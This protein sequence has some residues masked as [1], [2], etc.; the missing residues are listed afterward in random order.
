M[1]EAFMEFD[2]DALREALG[3]ATP[4][5]LPPPSRRLI[6]AERRR[7]AR[8]IL[9]RRFEGI[10]LYRPLAVAENFHRSTVEKRVATGSN[11]SGKTLS[12]AAEAVR[13]WTGMDPYNKYRPTDGNSI[14]VGLDLDHCAMFWRKCTAPGQFSIIPDQETGM[15]RSVRPDP[16]NPK[17]IDPYDLAN[18]KQWR[19]AP[20]LIPER[21]IASIAWEDRGKGIPR[22]VTFTTGW[23]CLFRSSDGKAAQGDAF[24]LAIFDEEQASLE[25]YY[26]IVRGLVGQH[27]EWTSKL[28]WSATSQVANVELANLR[29]RAAAG[30]PGVAQFDMLLR[31]NPYFTEEAKREFEA[32]L[33]EDERLT[34]IEGIPALTVR[35]IYPTYAPQIDV[36]DGGHGCEPFEVDPAKFCRYVVIDP[37]IKHCTV[38]C[39]AVDEL[40]KHATLYDGFQLSGATASRCAEEIKLREKGRPFEAVVIDARM[41]GQSPMTQYK[42]TIAQEYWTALMKVRCVPRQRG[43]FHGFYPSVSDIEARCERLRSWMEIR[44]DG[45]FA[46]TPV[47]RVMRGMFPRFDREVRMAATDPKNDK[48]RLKLEKVP[49]DW[50]DTAEYCAAFRPRYHAPSAAIPEEES[51]ALRMYHEWQTVQQRR[52]AREQTAGVSMYH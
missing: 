14:F 32:S 30:D 11:R 24:D 34:R 33:P 40:E 43:P 37:G 35:R 45:P 26:E 9:G 47:L 18:R 48:K 39:W 49:C 38:T 52:E 13:A 22:Y 44:G 7:V 21:M 12:C 10:R 25:W 28:I 8:K 50:L 4:Q 15:W 5:S 51:E 46:G 16:Q 27:G 42:T 2:P 29:D 23:R 36:E 17:R 20:P 31:D 19:D 6:D 1:N 41:A 3:I